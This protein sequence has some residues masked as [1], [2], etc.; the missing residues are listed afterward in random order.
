MFKKY[1]FAIAIL[2]IALTSLV[3]AQTGRWDDEEFSLEATYRHADT[4]LATPTGVQQFSIADPR[5]SPGI[6][7][8]YTHFIGGENRRG[9]FGIGFDGGLN[10][11]NTEGASLDGGPLTIGR[12]QY[13]MVLQDNRPDKSVR[14]G[15]KGTA[16]FAREI[17]RNRA[18]QGP[19]GS[20]QSSRGANAWTY[21]GGAFV[22]FG[23]HRK[24]L[25]LGLEYYHSIY[26]KQLAAF[27]ER[28]NKHN[29]EA[30]VGMT[31]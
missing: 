6:R 18:V 17:F 20:F 10:F 29:F 31:F 8:G 12:F 3:S 16:G 26:L 11:S 30:S 22:D 14:F 19:G 15:V 27:P 23:K 28:T 2:M 13:K 7:F 5:N 24:R 9:N 1:T 21:G 25:R 4:K